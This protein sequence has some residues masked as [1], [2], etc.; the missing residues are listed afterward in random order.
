MLK[1]MA[2]PRS[3]PIESQRHQS[4]VKRPRPFRT[5]KPT[6]LSP[7]GVCQRAAQTNTTWLIFDGF[8]L[9]AD[10]GI[11]TMQMVFSAKCRGSEKGSRV[12]VHTC[13][14][15]ID[16]KGLLSIHQRADPEAPDCPWMDL[17]RSTMKS[18][19]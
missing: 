9:Q 2:K 6:V 1:R 12:K 10:Q 19:L 16:G 13:P 11:S 5:V 17:Q 18:L 15:L 8:S 7:Y 14:E 4:A 3:A